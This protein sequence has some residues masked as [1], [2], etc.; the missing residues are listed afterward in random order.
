MTTREEEFAVRI[1]EDDGSLVCERPGKAWSIQLYV[2]RFGI[3]HVLLRPLL[4]RDGDFLPAR[5]YGF[6]QS[7]IRK[8][9]AI[10]EARLRLRQPHLGSNLPG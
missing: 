3:D 1:I 6:K 10:A 5:E 8:T 2:D 9:R 7:R 4:D